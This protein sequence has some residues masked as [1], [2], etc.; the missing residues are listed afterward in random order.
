MC[1][2]CGIIANN[3]RIDEETLKSMTRILSHR[4]P[5]NEGFHVEESAGLGHRRLSI[6][7][8]STGEQPIYNET[9]SICIVFN[10]EIYNYRELKK[11]LQLRGH[12]FA[13]NSDTEVIIHLFEDKGPECLR[14]LRG[15][16]ALAI[17]DQEKRELFL[18][19][20]R[21]G[22]KPL[23]YAQLSNEFIFASELKSILLW[24][25]VFMNQC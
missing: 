23:Y 9:G 24:E 12:H 16:F 11:D 5:D 4:G 7:D 13:T 10:G 8:L 19:R 17:W 6:I 25:K 1:G 18:A 22:K 21:V 20:D 14:D 3:G 15:M 2:I